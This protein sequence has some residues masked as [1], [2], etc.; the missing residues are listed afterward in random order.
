MYLN[1]SQRVLNYLEKH[2]TITT[3][4]CYKK[5]DIVDLQKVIFNLKKEG[6]KIS[7]KWVYKTNLLGKRIKFKRYKLEV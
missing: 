4:E 1:Q 2:G 7:D 5:L 3:M 6:Y